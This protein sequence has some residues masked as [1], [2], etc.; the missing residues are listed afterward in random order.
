MAYLAAAAGETGDLEGR[1]RLMAFDRLMA[2]RHCA[3]PEGYESLEAFNQALVEHVTRHGTR[4][5]EPVTK[6]TR[7]GSQTGELLDEN[8][9]PVAALE[10]AVLA[11]LPEAIVLRVR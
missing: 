10:Q 7:L 5:W 1:D 3:A 4:K 8:P 11:A 2:S 9:G 6:T